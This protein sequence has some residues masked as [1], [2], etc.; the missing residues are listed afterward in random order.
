[1]SS[2]SKEN[3]LPREVAKV[4]DAY[5]SALLLCFSRIFPAILNAAIDL[6]LFDIIA[7]KQSSCGS[8]LS[9]SEIASLL[10]NYEHPELANRLERMLTVLASYS[11]LNCSIRTNEDGKRERVYALSPIGQYFASDNDGGSLGPLSTLV[12]RGYYDIWKDVKDAIVDPN[13]NNHF[14][15][16]YGMPAYQYM[17]RDK[18]L[19]HIF[20]KA[21]AHAGPLDMKR[22]LELYKGFEGISTLVDVGG[23]SGQGLK[24][25]I[26]KY[27]SI[28][29]INYD[30]PQVVQDAPSF[31]GI[32]HVRGDM[33][34]SV[35]KGDAILL[36][37]V[38]H[39]W[40]D[41]ECVKFLKN[42]HQ[43][44][45]QHGKVIVLDYI[46]PEIPDS[47][48]ISKHTCALDNLMFMVHGG[49]ERTEKEFESLCRNSGFSRFHVS[50]TDVSA[51]S[52][53]MEFYK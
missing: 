30:L 27:P 10:P 38:C 24:L 53:V 11:L 22:I 32:E 14:E 9:A 25:I 33:F 19:N 51:M 41:E 12:H 42:C 47:S 16:V 1:M 36:K 34:E 37:L 5:L 52:G 49:K 31:P 13:N 44:L 8:S 48:R 35:P 39:N 2:N 3:E 45:P 50:C 21:M 26:S 7:K 6:N 40:S 18:E 23:G 29:G 28:K 43:A 15:K 17:K 20:N 4:D 46:I